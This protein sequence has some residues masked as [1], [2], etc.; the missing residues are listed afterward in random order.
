G[1]RASRAPREVDG[2]GARL[3]LSSAR[4]ADAYRVREDLRDFVLFAVHALLKA[5]PFSHVCLVSCRNVL[6]YLDRDLQE[7]VCSTFNYA[8]NPGG[9]LFLGAAETAENPPG[10]FRNVDRHARIYQSTLP[11]GAKPQALPRLMGPIRVREQMLPLV[12]TVSPTMALSEAAAH[13]R[14]IEQIAPPSILVDEAH[15]V[16]HLSD[17]AGRYLLPS[18]GPL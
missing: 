17:T 16:V 12:Q 15:R 8:L 4:E 13:R 11:V 7:Q 6:I 14:A 10:L 18:G 3:R 2:S 5:P 1:E 9:Y